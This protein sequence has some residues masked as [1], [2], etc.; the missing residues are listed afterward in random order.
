MTNSQ[1]ASLSC[2]KAPLWGLRPALYYCQT[3]A[4][5]LMCNSDTETNWLTVFMEIFSVYSKNYKRH[6][7][8]LCGW[9]AVSLNVKAGG[10]CNYHSDL[11]VCE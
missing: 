5:L 3:V 7:N 6:I 2:N 10:A 1:L 11:I 4:G 9:N 8:T